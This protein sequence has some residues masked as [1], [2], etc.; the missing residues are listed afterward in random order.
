MSQNIGQ[1][2][3]FNKLKI[4][5]GEKDFIHEIS[6]IIPVSTAGI[7]RRINGI[8]LLT[9]DEITLLSKKFKISY[10]E[11]F[12]YSPTDEIIFKFDYVNQDFVKYLNNITQ[13]L[14]HISS[15]EDH[16]M[17]YS[18]K[19]LPIWHYFTCKFLTNFKIFYWLRTIKKDPDFQDKKFEFD[20]IPNQYLVA[21]KKSLQAYSKVNS[22]ELWTPSSLNVMIGQIKYYFESGIISKTQFEII[23]SKLLD[24]LDSIKNEA[25]KGIKGCY[26]KK[27][28]YKI[29]LSEIIGGDNVVYVRGGNEQITFHPPVLM[30]YLHTKDIK[31]CNYI[32]EAF[33]R[34]KGTAELISVISEKNRNALFNG[35]KHNVL[36]LKKNHEYK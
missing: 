29:Y 2:I 3:L 28:S 33:D 24:L 15:F 35:F 20:C 5:V 18:V 36:K 17:I 13:N 14:N 22:E 23:T 4:L 10:N 11:L 32:K 26:S 30:N 34:A 27:G 25:A 6:N 16:I 7:Y 8:T 12:S 9:I 21:A 31:F 19:D 1:K